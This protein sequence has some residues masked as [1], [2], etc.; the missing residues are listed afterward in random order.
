LLKNFFIVADIGHIF[1]KFVFQYFYLHIMIVLVVED[2]P[3][4]RM[5]LK[6]LISDCDPKAVLHQ[7]DSFPA[8]IS[9][10]EKETVDIVILDI[11]IPGGENIK[12]IERIREKQKDVAIL[13]H[14][15]YDE[16]VY[17]LPYIRAGADGFLSKQAS[18]D[19]FKAAWA[20][21]VSKRRYVSYRVQ[22]LLLTNIAEN[23]SQKASNPI[24][25][26]SPRE[27]IVMQL[28]SE[29]KWTKE[30]AAIMDLKENTISTYKR[31]IYDKLDV[32]DPIELSKK[33]SLLKYL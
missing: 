20:A 9:I 31:R 24:L 26:L 6:M 21:L 28:M 22:Q 17:A 23:D 8:S 14:S 16:N 19:E 30:I 3:L 1:Y 25:S 27:L 13:I 32:K 33:V 7:A 12:M 5:G 29:G 2:H 11:D 15:G 4:I 10:L 18:P